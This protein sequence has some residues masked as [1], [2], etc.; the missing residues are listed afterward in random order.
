MVGVEVVSVLVGKLELVFMHVYKYYSF[1]FLHEW[2]DDDPPNAWA[3]VSCTHV[4]PF[5]SAYL[6]VFLRITR[7]CMFRDWQGPSRRRTLLI[8]CISI[9]IL[10]SLV[11]K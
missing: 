6:H 5:P 3:R 11:Q 8:Y 10:D 1:F 7:S 2:G 9:R 4:I